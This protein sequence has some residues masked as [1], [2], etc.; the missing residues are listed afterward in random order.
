MPQPAGKA[1][2]DPS[3]PTSTLPAASCARLAPMKL[4]MGANTAALGVAASKN[5]SGPPARPVA[6]CAP[7]DHLARVGPKIA[8][9]K[10]VPAHCICERGVEGEGS[11]PLCA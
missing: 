3:M 8:L 5:T 10:N 11:T 2:N 7:G 1:V 4:V 6:M 9:L